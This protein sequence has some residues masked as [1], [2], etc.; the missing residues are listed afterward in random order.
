MNE[1][2]TPEELKARSKKVRNLILII[3]GGAVILALLVL[4]ALY[5]FLP[6][7]PVAPEKELHFYPITDT[8]IFESGEYHESDMVVSYCADPNGMGLTEAITDEDRENFDVGVQFL[9]AYLKTVIGGDVETYRSFFTE[10]YLRSHEIPNF[11]QQML[12]KMCIYYCNT[13]TLEGG[14]Q[15][16]TYRLEYMIRKNNGTFRN[17]VESD[18]IR[19]QFAVLLI[20]GEGNVRIEDLY[21]RQNSVK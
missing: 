20:D 13:E 19:P 12:Y 18:A 17:D 8:N 9:E 2:I 21:T 10:S 15:R 14:M 1:Q 16:V 3:V 11:T 6:E 4:L 7:P 5:L